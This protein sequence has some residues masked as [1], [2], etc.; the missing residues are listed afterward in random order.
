M[1]QLW[2]DDV[3]RWWLE[4]MGLRKSGGGPRGL[5]ESTSALPNCSVGRSRAGGC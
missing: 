3:G 2:V 5:S 1:R 4:A